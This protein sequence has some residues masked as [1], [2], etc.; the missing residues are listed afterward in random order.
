MPSQALLLESTDRIRSLLKTVLTCQ[1]LREDQREDV[2]QFLRGAEGVPYLLV[3]DICHVLR[4]EQGGEGPWLH[5]VLRG[6][7]LWL[8][9]PKPREKVSNIHLSRES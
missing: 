7:G 2:L 1:S 9:L 6:S 4:R 8:P 3:R 5:H